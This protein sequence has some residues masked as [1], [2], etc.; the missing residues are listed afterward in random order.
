MTDTSTSMELRTIYHNGLSNLS[1]FK[2]TFFR[3]CAVKSF[4]TSF[5]SLLSSTI[6]IIYIIICMYSISV[7]CLILNIKLM[8]ISFPHL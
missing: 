3:F 8:F 2:C 5:A 4:S 1:M 6:Y 7:P